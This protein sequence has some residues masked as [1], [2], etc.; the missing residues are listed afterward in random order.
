[1]HVHSDMR[2]AIICIIC[3]SGSDHNTG[4]ITNLALRWD[5]SLSTIN[6]RRYLVGVTFDLT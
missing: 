1:M 3:K 5:S 2:N 6:V 4:E